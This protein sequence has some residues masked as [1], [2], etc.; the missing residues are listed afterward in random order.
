MRRPRGQERQHALLLLLLQQLR[1][2]KLLCTF[3]ALLPRLHAMLRVVE[4][5]GSVHL[6]Q[7]QQ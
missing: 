2:K 6:S 4:W 3:L 1:R 7:P 5:L